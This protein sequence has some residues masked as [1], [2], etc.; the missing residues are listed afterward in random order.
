MGSQDSNVLGRN[1]ENQQ[2]G[3]HQTEKLMQV[4]ETM[5]RMKTAYRMG[6][7]L[8]QLLF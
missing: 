6:E 7:N 3:S 4:K 2:M 8:C 5:K 1:T